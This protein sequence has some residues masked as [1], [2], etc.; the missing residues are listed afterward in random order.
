MEEDSYI[1][2]LLYVDD[3]LIAVK[4]NLD[5]VKLKKLLNSEFDM[6]DLGSNKED[7]RHGDL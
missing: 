1:Y 2:L 4:K 5:I 7:S 6:K 3:V